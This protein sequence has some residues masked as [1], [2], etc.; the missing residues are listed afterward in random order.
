MAT[1]TFKI[2]F[3]KFFA[4]IPGANKSKCIMHN[5]TCVF[6]VYVIGKQ[7]C[8][9]IDIDGILPKGSYLPC[10]S[11]AGRALLAGYHRYA[12]YITG[13]LQGVSNSHQWVPLTNSLYWKAL[14][15]SLLLT[16]TIFRNTELSCG[17]FEMLW[18]WYGVTVILLLSLPHLIHVCLVPF[19][20][21][22][23]VNW[24]VLGLQMWH[25]LLR[26][27]I[28]FSINNTS[29]TISAWF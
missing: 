12:F 8:H 19:L 29:V 6:V 5:P 15:F 16:W 21:A 3:S 22:H 23:M 20:H 25:L 14:V 9:D 11:M 26:E 7:W 4:Y 13:P 28:M 24:N 27:S 10:V 17:W 2:I 1:D 18:C